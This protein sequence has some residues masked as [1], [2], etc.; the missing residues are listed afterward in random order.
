[1]W[2][3]LFCKSSR[4]GTM[5]SSSDEEEVSTFVQS[6]SEKY[7]P[8]PLWPRP[9]SGGSVHPSRISG[10]GWETMQGDLRPYSVVDNEGFRQ[11]LNECEPRYTIPTRRFIT[12]TAVPQ[13]YADV[14]HQ[15][16]EAISSANRAAITCDA[17][18]S[19][20][21]QSYVTLTGHHSSPDWEMVSHV[22]QTRAMLE[23]HTGANIADLL[24]DVVHEWRILCWWQRMP[25]IR[26]SRHNWWSLCTWNALRTVW[27]WP[28][29]VHSSCPLPT[30]GISLFHIKWERCSGLDQEQWRWGSRALH[31][32]RIR[33]SSRAR[34]GK[35]LRLSLVFKVGLRGFWVI[36]TSWI[37]SFDLS[38][39]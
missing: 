18:T 23:S 1:M 37:L 39:F 15:V 35:L 13:L 14:K 6:V 26:Q 8:F 25:L 10:Q 9:G 28:L 36:D 17:W 33:D 4:A 29:N 30:S 32:Y 12:E 31:S 38:L 7:N 2:L 34:S 27:I 16:T 3:S 19:R 5:E 21:T 24:R 11:L 20:A 22:L